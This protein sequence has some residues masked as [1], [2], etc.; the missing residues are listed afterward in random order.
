MKEIEE[1][2][3]SWTVFRNKCEEK[4]KGVCYINNKGWVKLRDYHMEQWLK[5]HKS[6]F[7]FMFK[8]KHQY[9]SVYKTI[10]C[11]SKWYHVTR[12]KRQAKFEMNVA[13]KFVKF[14][15][16]RGFFR[17]RNMEK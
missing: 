15:S 14:P 10:P 4:V 3:A 1:Y 16:W 13:D 6:P 9:Y 12:V 8:L 7:G 2:L 11:A 17:N 5:N